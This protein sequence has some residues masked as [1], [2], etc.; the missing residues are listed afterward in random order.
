M[1][2]ESLSPPP[3]SQVPTPPRK[4]QPPYNY[5]RDKLSTIYTI[6]A[7]LLYSN[8]IDKAVLF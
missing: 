4:P 1:V 8:E 6:V 3:P 2:A 7:Y 5:F